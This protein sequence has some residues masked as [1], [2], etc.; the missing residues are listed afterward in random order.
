MRQLITLITAAAIGAGCVAC[1]SA[2]SDT[3]GRPGRLAAHSGRVATTQPRGGDPTNAATATRHPSTTRPG[4]TVVLRG[5]AGGQF[6][7]TAREFGMTNLA[8]SN[9]ASSN[10]PERLLARIDALAKIAPAEI[11]QDLADIAK[12]E[13]AVLGS[14]KI[15]PTQ[16]QQ[17]NDRGT[18]A[19][20]RHVSA[21]LRDQC[22]IHP[23]R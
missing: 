13:H 5:S 1:T 17:V 10:H 12:L 14:A 22:G 3:A 8:V 4:R 23:I 2:A 15:D 9:S 7:I 6:C 18:R 16:L 19:A 21:Y 11:S 20:L